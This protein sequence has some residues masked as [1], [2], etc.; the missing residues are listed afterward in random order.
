M[1]SAAAA[2]ISEP[3]GEEI[4]RPA[5][6]HAVEHH[7]RR[8][9]VVDDDP[10]MLDVMSRVLALNAFR[11]DTAR[12]VEEAQPLA[13]GGRYH[14][15]LLDLILPDA[16]GLSLYRRIARRRPAL[17]PRVIFVTGMLDRSEVRRFRRLVDNRLLLKPFDLNELLAAVRE[18]A[19]LPAD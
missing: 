4:A 5:G 12:S 8:I 16:N 9:L 19:A 3:S 15:I 17:K 14:G 13:L 18:V 6:L 10:P 1:K 11:V 2:I 7:D